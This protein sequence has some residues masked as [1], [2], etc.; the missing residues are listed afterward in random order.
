MDTVTVTVTVDLL[1]YPDWESEDVSELGIW[2][3]CCV[4]H[5]VIS[6]L[7]VSQAGLPQGLW[8]LTMSTNRDRAPTWAQCSA[9]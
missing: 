7:H 5:D 6:C 9:S 4:P 3:P 2:H 8:V 1:R